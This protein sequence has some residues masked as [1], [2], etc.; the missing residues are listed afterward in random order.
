MS[1]DFES[2]ERRYAPGEPLPTPIYQVIL[3]GDVED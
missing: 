2:E 1:E 3:V